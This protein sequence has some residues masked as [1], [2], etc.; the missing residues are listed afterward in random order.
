MYDLYKINKKYLGV[1]MYDIEGSKILIAISMI[2]VAATLYYKYQ[3]Q[4]VKAET[5]ILPQKIKGEKLR[6][7]S[8]KTEKVTINAQ[9]PVSKRRVRIN[10]EK[11]IVY[12]APKTYEKPSTT[13]KKN[14]KNIRRT[15]ISWFFSMIRNAIQ[16]MRGVLTSWNKSKKPSNAQKEESITSLDEKHIGKRKSPEKMKWPR[17]KQR[18]RLWSL[19]INDV[20]QDQFRRM[21]DAQEE[22]QTLASELQENRGKNAQDF[23]RADEL[24][25]ERVLLAISAKLKNY[26]NYPDMTTE[27]QESIE[28]ILRVIESDI[29]KERNE[30]V[31]MIKRDGMSAREQLQILELRLGI[32]YRDTT[33]EQIVRGEGE[34]K[35]YKEMKSLK[36][37]LDKITTLG[38]I[39]QELE[40]NSLSMFPASV[41]IQELNQ[42]GI[43]FMCD[44]EDYSAITRESKERFTKKFKSEGE[45]AAPFVFLR[46]QHYIAGSLYRDQDGRY[47]L[48]TIDQSNP[49]GGDANKI[50]EYISDAMQNDLGKQVIINSRKSDYNCLVDERGMVTRIQQD[51]INCGP[52]ALEIAKQ[53]NLEK[54]RT[55]A[56]RGGSVND[57]V[58]ELDFIQHDSDVKDF[59]GNNEKKVWKRKHAE[60][61]GTKTRENIYKDRER[62]FKQCSK[63]LVDKWHEVGKL[64]QGGRSPSLRT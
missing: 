62:E 64:M 50:Q 16:R 36:N 27:N 10:E 39:N 46:N 4:E 37:T 28:R 15:N 2:A 21:V 51:G 11:N 22:C 53:F 47:T 5:P 43:D 18:N 55:V 3:K 8:P 40:D 60:S 19:T 12:E 49:K 1:K 59:A 38:Q 45:M 57:F 23:L 41:I 31:W 35:L 34:F 17:K 29:D 7:I 24:G 9:K 32:K 13:T 54:C 26:L 58:K 14:K 61:F 52:L 25:E 63:E 56:A 48:I 30:R 42:V 20:N 44:H 33:E 6:A